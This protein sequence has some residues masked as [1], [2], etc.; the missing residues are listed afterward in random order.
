MPI[1]LKK[2]KTELIAKVKLPTVEY[3]VIMI[4]NQLNNNDSPHYF[5]LQKFRKKIAN[6]QNMEV[7]I[8]RMISEANYELNTLF[9]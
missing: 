6:F 4:F 2:P 8:R 9:E 3:N 7:A 1:K 5:Q